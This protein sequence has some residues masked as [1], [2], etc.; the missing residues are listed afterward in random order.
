MLDGQIQRVVDDP[1]EIYA[2]ANT[3]RPESLQAPLVVT[4]PPAKV[5]LNG[6]QLAP[7]TAF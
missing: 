6:K 4:T 3:G 7:M 1:D 2:L 5:R